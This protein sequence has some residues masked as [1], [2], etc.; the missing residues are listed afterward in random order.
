MSHTYVNINNGASHLDNID[1]MQSEPHKQNQNPVERNIQ[2][3]KAMTNL[4]HEQLGW[5]TPITV[6]F[7]YTHD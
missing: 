5:L 4:S 6:A 7:G 1:D 2:E 3:V